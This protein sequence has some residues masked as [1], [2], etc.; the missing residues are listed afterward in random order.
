[1]VT[2]EPAGALDIAAAL[3]S[4][5][6]ADTC[7]EVGRLRFPVHKLMSALGLGGE[8]AAGVLSPAVDQADT[9][10]GSADPVEEGLRFKAKLQVTVPS[11]SPQT[12]RFHRDALITFWQDLDEVK[13]C[14]FLDTLGPREVN[15]QEAMFEVISSEASYLRS[16]GVAVDH[17]WASKK[18]R[19][20]VSQLEHHVLFSNLR[21]VMSASEGFLAALECLLGECVVMPQL[22]DLVLQ[23]CPRF[24]ALYVPYLSNM[25][26]QEAL[27]NKLLQENKRFT[28]ALKTLE[29]DPTC[30]RQSL[31]SFLVLPF[32]RITRLKLLMEVITQCNEGVQEMKRMEELVCLEMLLDFK[33]VKLL[34]LIVKGRFLF[35]EG[36]LRQLTKVCSDLRT[37]FVDVYLH[38]F[39]DLLVISLQKEHRFRVL[40]H[41][42]FPGHVR[43]EPLNASLLGLPADSFLLHLSQNH[44]GQATALVL[45]APSR[46]DKE[47]WMTVLSDPNGLE[48][49]QRGRHAILLPQPFGQAVEEGGHVFQPTADLS[50]GAQDR[51]TLRLLELPHFP[52]RHVTVHEQVKPPGVKECAENSLL[53]MWIVGL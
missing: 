5:S 2:N 8:D 15:R 7:A 23:H 44:A 41:A 20:T 28:S 42:S 14:G 10:D 31:K 4:V 48:S 3:R 30:Q 34:P 12:S 27:I 17:F 47:A 9:T 38:L 26:F 37:S 33:N 22:A 18:L 50:P 39:N 29:S 11:S 52:L 25:M 16:L 21:H 51:Q 32:Q 35:Q 45:A 40:D 6:S 46:S 53:R 49:V 24:Q 36:P 13:E 19:R 1:M 43:A